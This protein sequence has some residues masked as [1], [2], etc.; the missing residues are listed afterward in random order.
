MRDALS[1]IRQEGRR[2]GAAQQGRRE[3]HVDAG[4][5]PMT[6]Y[7][8]EAVRPGFTGLSEMHQDSSA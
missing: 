6:G 7:A 4:L 3:A 1:F 5:R 8:W 2:K